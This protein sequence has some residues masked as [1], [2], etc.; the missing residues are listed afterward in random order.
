MNM[1]ELR[2]AHKEEIKSLINRRRVEREI[3]SLRHQGRMEQSMLI[4][5]D[6]VERSCALIKNAKEMTSF[7]YK[8][9]KEWEVMLARHIIETDALAKK[10]L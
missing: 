6:P 2:H 5:A 1:L 10:L 3:L 8:Y 9:L 4:I 7:T